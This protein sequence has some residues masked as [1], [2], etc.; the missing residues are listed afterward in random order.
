[1]VGAVVGVRHGMAAAGVGSPLVS[2]IAEIAAG[3]IVYVPAALLC[4]PGTA[5]D[6]LG[7][8]RKAYS[9]SAAAAPPN[10]M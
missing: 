1:M 9:R 10:K 2:L 4:A 5:R 7:L 3:A 6:F 8:L